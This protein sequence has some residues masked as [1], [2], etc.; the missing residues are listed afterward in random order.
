MILAEVNQDPR[1]FFQTWMIVNSVATFVLTI[2]TIW[3]LT[4]NKKQRREV[5]F[6]FEPASKDDFEAHMD[7]TEQRFLQMEKQRQEDLEASS[8]SRKIIYN[9]IDYLRAEL[10]QT[11][12]RINEHNEG[13][14]LKIHERVNEILEAVSQLR[15]EMRR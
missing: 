10:H 4:S 11:E 6:S 8:E 3:A 13:R 5:S 15:G 14:S 7:K 1:A 9:K 2:I 12:L